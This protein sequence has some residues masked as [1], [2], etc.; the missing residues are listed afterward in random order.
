LA[1]VIR[2]ARNPAFA[3]DHNNVFAHRRGG[4]VQENVADEDVEI[5]R[6]R[7]ILERGA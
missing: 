3:G 4:I 2:D 6:A 7:K 1:S 5:R